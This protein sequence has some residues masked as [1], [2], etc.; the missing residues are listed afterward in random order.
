MY[1][2]VCVCVLRKLSVSVQCECSSVQET[3]L[4][5]SK[6]L[7]LSNLPSQPGSL[8][9]GEYYKRGMLLHYT[10]T[11]ARARTIHTCDNE[12]YFLLHVT[13]S[14]ILVTIN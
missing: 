12:I 2:R 3:V 5:E 11:R 4:Y 1:V 6:A 7:N 9:V 14:A 8:F 10:Y 13:F